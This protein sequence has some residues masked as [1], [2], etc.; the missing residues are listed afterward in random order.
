MIRDARA[1]GIKLAGGGFV[2]LKANAA[3]Y[4]FINLP[5]EPWHWSTNGN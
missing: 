1:A 2:W 3:R 4:G 5:S